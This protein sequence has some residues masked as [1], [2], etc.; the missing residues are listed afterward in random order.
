MNRINEIRR[1]NN[2]TYKDI[3]KKTDLT[4]SYICLLANGRRKNPSKETMIKI[5]KALNSTVQEVFF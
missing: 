1:R 4:E 2:L 5:A 3:A